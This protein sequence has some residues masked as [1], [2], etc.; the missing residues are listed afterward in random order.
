MAG[1]RSAKQLKAA[2]VSMD[3][4]GK[5][6]SHLPNVVCYRCRG[7]ASS[8]A[9]VFIARNRAEMAECPADSSHNLIASQTLPGSSPDVGNGSGR[10]PRDHPTN[11]VEHGGAQDRFGLAGPRNRD[12]GA[13]SL[14]VGL[15]GI[16]TGRAKRFLRL[17]QMQSHGVDR[18]AAEKT[19][20]RSC[21]SRKQFCEEV[22]SRS[23]S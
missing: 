3:G 13:R 15:W 12:R 17:N 5:L 6:G 19:L 22:D 20:S 16:R 8:L 21:R 7:Q 2:K 18:R 1:S 23:A 11:A 14:I 10:T 4:L 9:S